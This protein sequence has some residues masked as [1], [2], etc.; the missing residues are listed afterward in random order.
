MGNQQREE[1][2]IEHIAERL[3]AVPGVRAVMLGGSRATGE[4]RPDSDFDFAVYYR[5]RFQP[6]DIRRLGWEGTISEIGGWGGG[7]MN[8]GAWLKVEDHPIDVHYRDLDEVE[9]YV[10]EA[11]RGIFHVER[12]PFYLAG[13]PSYA[14]VGE[15]A[16][17]RTLAGSLPK[18]DYPALLREKAYHFWHESALLNLSY[19]EGAYAARGDAIGTAGALARAVVEESHARL[20]ARGEWVLNEKRIVQRAGLAH[21]APLFA[22]LSQEA[23]RLQS[24]IRE[25]RDEIAKAPNG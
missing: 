12:L 2:F 4:H 18:P 23:A 3:A 22:S 19:A 7:L 6:Q 16:L 11:E 13:I 5:G 14:I 8:G 10:E 21:L 17:G 15:L 9:R 25:V 20:A 1:S 24:V